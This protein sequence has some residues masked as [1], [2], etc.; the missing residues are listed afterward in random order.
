MPQQEFT[1][2]NMV[3]DVLNNLRQSSM[4]YA[5]DMSK[6]QN[7]DLRNFLYQRFQELEDFRHQLY[8]FASRK[9]MTKV[10]PEATPQDCQAV[11]DQ[12]CSLGCRQIQNA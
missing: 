6:C 5:R 4:I 2:A 9:N 3:M 1:D 11:V 12:L 8:Q 10:S 7:D